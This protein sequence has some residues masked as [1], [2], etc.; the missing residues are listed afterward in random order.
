MEEFE[1]KFLEVDVPELERK[2]VSIGAE[3]VGEYN[4]MRVLMDYPDFR[5]NE[6]HS[7]IRL[8]T[9]GTQSTLT[10]KQ[11]IGS[12]SDDGSI[13]DDGMKEI[14]VIVE[15][16]N[17]TFEIFKA[18]GFVVKREEH[19]RRI[20]YRKGMVVF[21]IDFWPQIPPY[22]EIES[23]SL[24][25]A[26]NAALELGFDPKDGLICSAKK[27]YKRYGIDKDEYSYVS[28]DKMVKK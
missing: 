7:W 16:Y 14:E 4:Y 6:S 18:I 3:K 12:K 25:N 26:Q 15:D 22:V 9:D 2:L 13:P 17:K 20:S 8:R 21:D 11:V 27:V 23:D 5:L 28:F 1:I 10:Y 19:N 24:V